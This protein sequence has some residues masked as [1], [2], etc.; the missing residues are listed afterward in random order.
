[1]DNPASNADPIAPSR[2]TG[3]QAALRLSAYFRPALRAHFAALEADDL[4]LRFGAH[5]RPEVLDDYVAAIDFSRCMVLGVFDDELALVGVAHLSPEGSDWEMGVSVLAPFRHHGVGS[6]L[7]RQAMREV[8]AAGSDRIS[9]H[10]L[11]EN[12]ALMHL[13]G[14]VG[15]A[16]V[17][18][19]G[20]SDGIILLPRPDAFERWA[21]LAAEQFNA[22]DFGIKAQLFMSRLLV[23]QLLRSQRLLLATPETG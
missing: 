3:V 23:R 6:L 12:H 10:F 1:M 5:L 20:D 17:A 8:R 15:A 4:Y 16:V 21:D 22:F 9:V 18:N 19:Q 2:P 13:I 11:S 7:L 14:K